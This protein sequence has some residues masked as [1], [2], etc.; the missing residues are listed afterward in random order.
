M[1]KILIVEDDKDLRDSVEEWLKSEHY[2]VETAGDGSLAM[3]LLKFYEFD[4]IVLDWQLPLASGIDVCKTFRAGGGTAPVLMLTGKKTTQEKV[5]G[6][7]CGADDY[8]TKPF[9]LDELS[10]R[11][12]AL[13]RRVPEGREEILQ[14]GNLTLDPSSRI[15]KKDGNE[16]R[17]IPKEFDLLEFLMRHPYDV[18]SA[19]AL[20]CRV[21][22][23]DKEVSNDAIFTCIKRLRKK[24]EDKESHQLIQTVHGLGYKFV[25]PKN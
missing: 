14:F 11:V 20:L 18:F 22:K 24:I 7:D 17:L 15:V 2:V 8:L 1:H 19:E 12:K 23:S 21:W 9:D 5:T 6:L 10:A 4:M 13:L 25:P 16:I 3:D